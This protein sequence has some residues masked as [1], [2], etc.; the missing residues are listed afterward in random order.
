M[1]WAV[2]N[3][4]AG[5]AFFVTVNGMLVSLSLGPIFEDVHKTRK[6][7]Y[8]QKLLPSGRRPNK[9]RELV[10]EVNEN[11]ENVLKGMAE[12]ID[13]EPSIQSMFLLFFDC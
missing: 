9:R 3:G 2:I 11:L 13:V 8:L 7:V 10:N 5:L 6:F 1:L 4:I 12:V